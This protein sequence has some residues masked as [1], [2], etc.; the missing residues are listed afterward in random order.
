MEDRKRKHPDH[1]DKSRKKHKAY[2][3]LTSN[4]AVLEHWNR[5]QQSNIN[6]RLGR[7][8][9]EEV[10]KQQ[11]L[12][13]RQQ[14]EELDK[15]QQQLAEQQQHIQQQTD[16]IRMLIHQQK[17]LIRQCKAS[18]IK[19]PLRTPDPSPL[20]TPSSPALTPSGTKMV[21]S[22]HSPS[23]TPTTTLTLPNSTLSHLSYSSSCR[24]SPSYQQPT[25][26][27]S[28]MVSLAASL[29]TVTS[30]N[31][32]TITS[33]PPPLYNMGGST[34]D[35]V[36]YPSVDPSMSQY[37]MPTQP[38]TH[39]F[40]QPLTSKDLTELTSREVRKLSPYDPNSVGSFVPPLP[41]EFDNILDIDLPLV[42]SGAGYGVGINDEDLHLTIPPDHNE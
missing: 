37:M 9:A 7:G 3:P 27:C 24:H 21:N 23:T 38:P 34:H 10:L 12:L 32:T 26:S 15:Q 8:P 13:I 20:T 22:A 11:E 6:R 16:Q 35:Y 39:E 5:I 36:P 28:S 42:G 17:I 14:A 4:E 41:E 40:M 18:G 31:S 1:G 25:L 30:D 19:L 2:S 33:Y 29:L